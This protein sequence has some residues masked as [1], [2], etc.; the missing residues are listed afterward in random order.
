MEKSIVLFTV[1]ICLILFITQIIIF[2]R[3]SEKAVTVH[4]ACAGSPTPGTP[5]KVAVLNPPTNDLQ[6]EDSQE[7][8][9]LNDYQE[10]WVKGNSMLLCGIRNDDILFTRSIGLKKTEDL[11]NLPKV[12][13]LK[14]E[15][16][17]LEDAIANG[18]N[19]QYKARRTWAILPFNEEQ[20]MAKVDE[21]M[22]NEIFQRLQRDY[23]ENFLSNEEMKKDC[24]NNRIAKY[25][26]QYPDCEKISSKD[27]LVIISTTLRKVDG[28]NKVFFSIHPARIA[29]SEVMYTFH[30]KGKDVQV[31]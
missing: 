26:R 24:L 11:S 10:F 25:C 31:A 1:I 2:L 22:Q 8:I 16:K 6:I 30:K 12:L 13:I 4:V 23:P 18:D 7:T 28:E 19:S 20:I 17:S 15:G 27:N 29:V 3:H 21:I 14:R 9:R 5:T